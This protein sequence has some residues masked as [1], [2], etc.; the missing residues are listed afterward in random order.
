M[1]LLSLL[2]AN[3]IYPLQVKVVAAVVAAVAAAA[4]RIKTKKVAVRAAKN[5]L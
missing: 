3:F 1:Q 4:A 2:V 5:N